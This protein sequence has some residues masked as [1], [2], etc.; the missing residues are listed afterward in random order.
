MDKNS[1]IIL[2]VAVVIWF[3]FAHV[4]EWNVRNRSYLLNLTIGTNN[5][6]LIL[7]IQLHCS[8]DI[9]NVIFNKQKCDIA[10]IAEWMTGL[11]RG[12]QQ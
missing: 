3:T 6:N 12:W 11:G 2:S 8:M 9:F 1:V 7:T 5:L 4:L 10:R